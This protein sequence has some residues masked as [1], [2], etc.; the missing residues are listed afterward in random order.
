MAALRDKLAILKERARALATADVDESGEQAAFATLMTGGHVLAVPLHQVIRG[1]SLV[2]LTEVPG[3]PDWL[4][5]LTSVE[6]HLVSLVDLVTLLGLQ[7]AGVA[8][9]RGALV[10]TTGR[11]EIG[12]A[13]EQLLGIADVPEDAFVP[14]PASDGPLTR[15]ARGQGPQGQ[16]LLL[17]DVETLFAD[18][19]LAGQKRT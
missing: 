5:G 7:R 8:D 11:R 6:G 3:A 16:D 13:A 4:L 12:L 2:H 15:A 10:V 19:R 18:P 1:A 9:V 17:L 14:L